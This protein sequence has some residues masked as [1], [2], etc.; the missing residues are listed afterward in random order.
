MDCGQEYTTK[1][2]DKVRVMKLKYE[3]KLEESEKDPTTTTSQIDAQE[4]GTRLQNMS[5][6]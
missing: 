1:R 5:E 6:H 2:Q 3:V 4:Y